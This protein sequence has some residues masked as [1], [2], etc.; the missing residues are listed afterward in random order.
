MVVHLTDAQLQ[1]GLEHIKQSPKDNGSLEMIVIRPQ[2]DGRTVLDE[3]PLSL[4]HGVHGDL[5][6]RKC[7]KTLP[8]GASHPEVQ[9]AIM[10]SRAV[11][12][13]AQDKNRWC[14]AGDNLYVDLD[15]SNENI[16][17]G[18]RFSVGTVILQITEHAHNGCVKFMNRFGKDG[19]KFVNSPLGKELHLRGIYAMVIQDGVVKVGDRMKKID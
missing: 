9:V 4:Q 2:E 14:L 5:W 6:E 8:D 3:C 18:Q 12:L 16:K 15:L 7:W 13:L 11:A 19:L 17:T 10:N 1:L